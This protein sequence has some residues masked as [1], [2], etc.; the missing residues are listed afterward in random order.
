MVPSA[1]LLAVPLSVTVTPELA[2][3]L[4]PALATGAVLAAPPLLLLLPLPPPPPQATSNRAAKPA[5]VRPGE[6]WRIPSYT[7]AQCA[8]GV[9]RRLHTA[10]ASWG[11]RELCGWSRPPIP[12]GRGFQ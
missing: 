12:G 11:L 1:S 8:R 5:R 2:A 3:W 10:S 6:D 7:G 9:Q 4:A